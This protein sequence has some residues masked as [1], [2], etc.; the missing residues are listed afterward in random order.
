MPLPLFKV[1]EA[2]IFSFD[3][4]YEQIIRKN[5]WIKKFGYM[6]VSES[7]FRLYFFRAIINSFENI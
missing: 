5:E 6:K 1:K 4:V 3:N 2:S 7:L